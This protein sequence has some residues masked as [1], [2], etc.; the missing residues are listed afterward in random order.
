MHK[1]Q[2]AANDNPQHSAEAQKLLNSTLVKS[3]TPASEDCNPSKDYHFAFRDVPDILQQGLVATYM[4]IGASLDLISLTEGSDP[5]I[6][7]KL[8]SILAMDARHNE[9]FRQQNNLEEITLSSGEARIPV[10]WSLTWASQSI[11]DHATCPKLPSGVK[12]APRLDRDVGTSA[13]SGVDK[14]ILIGLAT[15]GVID[16]SVKPKIIW[17]SGLYSPTYSTVKSIEQNKYTTKI[18]KGLEGVA[19]LALVRENYTFGY[20]TLPNDELIAGPAIVQ[21]S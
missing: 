3:R 2:V 4:G 20:P 19:F 14:E 6:A 17:L 13:T 5:D 9:Y 8:A 7:M 11:A 12:P 21:I 1:Y 15:G 16:M 18:P 10:D